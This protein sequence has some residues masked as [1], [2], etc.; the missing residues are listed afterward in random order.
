MLIG[1][2]AYRSN[3]DDDSSTDDKGD[4]DQ[5]LLESL[6]KPA[7]WPEGMNWGTLR[8]DASCMPAD[9]TCPT[10][11]KPLNEARQTTERVI[12]NLCKQSNGYGALRPRY[13]RSR[14]RTYFSMSKSG[15]DH[16]GE[17]S[18]LRRGDSLTICSA[19]W[20]P[21]TP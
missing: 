17:D 6:I 2:D 11:L 21:L 16:D 1:A 4:C 12:E 5:L 10:D 15:K 13:D 7:G 3:D 8:I 18:R 9:I 20:Q 14:A 19:I